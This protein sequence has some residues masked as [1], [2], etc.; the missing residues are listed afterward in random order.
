MG[1]P[2]APEAKLYYRATKPRFEEAVV[3]LKAGKSVGAV[4]LAGYTVECFLKAPLLD[5]TPVSLR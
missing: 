4:Y 3:V 2:Q 1:L 5:G